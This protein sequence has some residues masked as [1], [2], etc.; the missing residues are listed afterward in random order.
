MRHNQ[1]TAQPDNAGNTQRNDKVHQRRHHSRPLN[2]LNSELEHGTQRLAKT[3]SL[4]LIQ[5]VRSNNAV[6][7]ESFVVIFHDRGTRKNRLVHNRL[8]FATHRRQRVQRAE[9]HDNR[10]NRQLP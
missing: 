3:L 2:H 5:V 1:I 6:A 7:A 9:Q 8:N 4:I 10:H